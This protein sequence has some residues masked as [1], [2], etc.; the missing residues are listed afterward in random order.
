MRDL[1]KKISKRTI[2]TALPF[3]AAALVLIGLWAA[4]A[5]KAGMVRKRT[6]AWLSGDLDDLTGRETAEEVYP[7]AYLDAV[8]LLRTEYGAFLDTESGQEDRAVLPLLL[9]KTKID[10]ALPF[11]F[12]FPLDTEMTVTGP[13]LT[14]FAASASD[15]DT[16]KRT[17][18]QALAEENYTLRTVRV[19]VTLTETDGA[20]TAQPSQEAVAALYGGLSELYRQSWAEALQLT[21]SSEEGW[22]N[23]NE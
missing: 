11:V 16:L 1:L 7:Q 10:V 23:A 17:V 20:V 21:D 18:M 9:E 15:P 8:A 2:L 3:I 14:A 12:S 5:Q 4:H 13:D 19:P 6:D 22:E